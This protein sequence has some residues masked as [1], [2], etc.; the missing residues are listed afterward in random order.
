MYAPQASISPTPSPARCVLEGEHSC[1]FVRCLFSSFLQFLFPAC[2]SDFH[3]GIEMSSRRDFFFP[4]STY[5][6]TCITNCKK[7]IDSLYRVS[8]KRFYRRIIFYDT[9]LSSGSPVGQ[10]SRGEGGDNIFNPRNVGRLESGYARI[11]YFNFFCSFYYYSNVLYL[12]SRVC[13]DS[14]RR[15]RWI[16]SLVD[17]RP[18]K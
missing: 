16:C 8:T 15:Y 7:K 11:F 18:R 4:P 17:N 12:A 13:R 9:T 5:P 14:G 2:I 10:R 1:L 3:I 6:S